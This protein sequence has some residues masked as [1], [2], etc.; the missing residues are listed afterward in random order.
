[1]G[2]AFLRKRAGGE[3][4]MAFTAMTWQSAVM[5]VIGVLLIYLAV[6]H[7][8]EPSLLLPMGVGTILMNVPM[9]GAAEIVK[10]VY[11]LGIGGTTLENG[12]VLVGAELM[13]CLLFIG[14]G[15][16]LDFE[17]LFQ[18]PKVLIF[19]VFAQAGIFIAMGLALLCGFELKD[20]IS[21]GIIGAAD[22]PT[23]IIVADKAGSSYMGAIMVAAYSY[24]ALVPI[25]QP[26]VIRALTTQKERLIRTAYKQKRIPKAFKICFPV[27]VTVICGLAVP[28]S[29]SLVGTLMFGNL[30]REC[31]VVDSLAEVAKTTL[32]DL[33]TLFLGFAVSYKMQGAEFL[34]LDTLMILGFGLLAFVFDTAAGV[35]IAKIMNLFLKE[36]INPMIGAAGIS[37]F[38]MSARVVQKEGLK[39]DST[40]HLLM[41]AIG[42]NISG[43][44]CSAIIGGI[45][46]QLFI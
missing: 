22:A 26:L 4:F 45:L 20:A 5:L 34:R 19:G 32:T 10:S 15:A 33:I 42:A 6:R 25:I 2:E 43:Q 7:K 35:L 21:I 39:A 41:P 1:M 14:I 30:L 3:S 38:P 12:R 11:D 36:K 27:A 40:N 16:M 18:N 31:G 29:L 8:M 44:L 9:S 46:L 37:A 28:Q 17:P 24:I 13:P 23:A